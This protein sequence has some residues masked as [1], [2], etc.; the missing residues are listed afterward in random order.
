MY[1]FTVKLSC[2]SVEIQPSKT[3][4]YMRSGTLPALEIP[5]QA[6]QIS[7]TIL[8]DPA[9]VLDYILLIPFVIFSVVTG[10]LRPSPDMLS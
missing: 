1:R 6:S 5:L 4:S 10:S 3:M 7:A 2:K 8:Q 9:V